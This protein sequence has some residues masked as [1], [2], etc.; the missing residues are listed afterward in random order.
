MRHCNISIRHVKER[1]IFELS[2][3]NIQPPPPLMY[4]WLYTYLQGVKSIR[5]RTLKN[6]QR[7]RQLFQSSHIRKARNATALS[8]SIKKPLKH[9][10]KWGRGLGGTRPPI[11]RQGGCFKKSDQLLPGERAIL[12]KVGGKVICLPLQPRL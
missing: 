2:Q 8:K 11:G 1:L 4:Y 12:F 6:H 5:V 10:R 9:W 3:Q 7:P